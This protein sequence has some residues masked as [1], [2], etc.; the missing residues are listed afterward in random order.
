MLL[1]DFFMFSAYATDKETIK[2]LTVKNK[3]ELE[4]KIKRAIKEHG[5]EANLNYIDTSLITDMSELFED[6]TT[7]N[8]DISRWNVSKVTNMSWMFNTATK[9]NQNI[10]GWAD[11]TRRYITN[12]FSGATAMEILN[13]PSWAR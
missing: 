7:F 1:L 8:G 13:K 6:N 9:F 3:Y 10:S 12:M 5:S 11:K 2:T 4:Q